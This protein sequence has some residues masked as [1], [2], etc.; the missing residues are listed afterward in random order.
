MDGLTAEEYGCDGILCPPGTFQPSGAATIVGGCQPCPKTRF[1]EEFEPK[2]STVLGRTSCESAPYLVADQN[3]DGEVSPREALRY[4]YYEL[5]GDVWGDKYYSWRDLKVDECDLH[6]ITCNDCG[7]VIEI[8]LAEASLCSDGKSKNTDMC[9]GLPGEIKYLNATL[10]KF[11]APRRRYLS[12]RLPPDMGE[13][14]ELKILDLQG[15]PLLT[16][17]IPSEFGKL[18]N[19]QQLDLS[20]GSFN[21]TLPSEMFA[22]TSLEKINLSLNPLEGSLP[23]EVGNLRRLKELWIS[24][25]HLNGTLPDSLGNLRSIENLEIYGNSFTGSIPST[26]GQLTALKRIG[27]CRAMGFHCCPY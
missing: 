6:G 13:L 18:T 10:E 12:G 23:S 11:S 4:L 17:M 9:G 16:G 26:L 14:T 2:L 1:A 7:D 27:E 21:G 24:R 22:M 8:D 20:E 19:L 5:N 3:V 25:A 15:C